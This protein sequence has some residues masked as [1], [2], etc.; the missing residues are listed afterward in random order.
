[1]E[2]DGFDIHLTSTKPYRF[3]VTGS[4]G[5]GF[6]ASRSGDD[7]QHGVFDCLRPLN[8]VQPTVNAVRSTMDVHPERHEKA[9]NNRPAS[10][11]MDTWHHRL[12]HM[13]QHD[14][15]FLHRIGRI[16]IQ[17]TKLVTPCDYCLAAKTARKEGNGPTHALL[18]LECGSI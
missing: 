3:H 5:L 16:N 2:R 4:D 10:A 13:N 18:G 17:G 7:I 12:S 6:T 15:Q 1:M 14:L 11:S 8:A 9:R